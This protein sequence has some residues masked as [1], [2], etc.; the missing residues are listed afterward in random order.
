MGLS[1]TGMSCFETARVTGHRRDPVPPASMIPRMDGG[2]TLRMDRASLPSLPLDAIREALPG[3]GAL[4][5]GPPG[6]AG[7]DSP[8]RGGRNAQTRA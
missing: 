8:G 2:G 4:F 7:F 6:E 5:P 1:K 3:S